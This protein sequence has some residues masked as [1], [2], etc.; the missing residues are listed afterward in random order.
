MK[1]NNEQILNELIVSRI[2]NV[3]LSV[4]VI[5]LGFMFVISHN[6]GIH[7]VEAA[8]KEYEE[9]KIKTA[10]D[11]F[12]MQIKYDELESELYSTAE[13]LFNVCAQN[14]DLWN[15][16]NDYKDQLKDFTKRKE[17]YDKYEY[18]LYH[19]GERT[20]ITYDQ[21]ILLEDLV[22]DKS[23]NDPD[24]YLSIIMTES[25]GNSK[26]SNSTS[27]AKGYSQFLD[28]TSRFV[29][30][31][32]CG[33][34]LDTWTPECI[35]DG[36]LCIEMMVAYINYLYEYHNNDLYAA[37][38]SYRG[39]DLQAYRDTIDRYLSNSGKSISIISKNIK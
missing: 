10:E 31:K 36:E 23:I 30:T 11:S 7:N 33:Y 5:I 24:F 16:Y 2:L 22:K 19:S 38:N 20:D 14:E 29:Y 26:A 12:E 28:S 15:N 1:T 37:I 17:L 13:L 18:A 39:A 32:L 25:G 3:I 21:L 34:E 4:I 6:N 35:Y 27:S 8:S 9:Y